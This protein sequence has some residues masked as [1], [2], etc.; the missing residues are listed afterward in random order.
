MYA[1]LRGIMEM[2]DGK[3]FEVEAT[4]VDESVLDMR[5]ELKS[6]YF[7]YMELVEATPLRDIHTDKAC[8][9]ALVGSY[10]D[11]AEEL[12]NIIEITEGGA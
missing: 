2:Y 8:A 12:K 10:A 3:P 1:A 7:K 5:D 11:F 4:S 6:L 9:V